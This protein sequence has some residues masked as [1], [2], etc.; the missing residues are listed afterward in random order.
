MHKGAKTIHGKA[1]S[2][3][4][5]TVI[6][7]ANAM[8]QTVPPHF[9]MPGKTRRALHGYALENI[10]KN[11]TLRDAKFSVSESGWTKDG[12]ARLWFEQTFLPNIGNYRPQLL[13]CD[14]HG[15]HNNIEFIE[16]ARSN[17][18]VVMELP[19]HTSNW[20]QPLDR[21]FFKSL[22][23]AWNKEVDN[24][25]HTTG[26]AI[27]HAQFFRLFERAW[28]VST[29]ESNIVSGFKATG[30]FPLNPSAIPAEAFVP[31]DL[32]RDSENT[33]NQSSGS[34]SETVTHPTATAAITTES[35]DTSTCP[36]LAD[37]APNVC[38]H[39][40]EEPSASSMPSVLNLDP[41]LLDASS[42]E[43]FASSFE[44]IN[45]L[46][47][48]VPIQESPTDLPLVIR[49]DGTLELTGMSDIESTTLVTGNGETLQ[50]QA[51][52]NHLLDIPK[53]VVEKVSTKRKQNAEKYFVIT[54]DK[55][56]NAK[57][58]KEEKR[59]E[60]ER[61]KTEKKIQRE[62]KKKVKAEEKVKKMNEKLARKKKV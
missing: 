18:I 60:A 32:Y 27:G 53:V 62:N 44:K 52:L 11:S 31:S 33:C 25:I 24:F 9:I 34:R 10:D 40:I 26:L 35:S 55:A 5:I 47:L 21:S 12:I 41:L 30:I 19:S 8:G 37:I 7:C 36:S 13:I 2:R 56:F 42:D 54:S 49:P 1:G 4:M 48:T 38:G 3:E 50:E 61:V 39:W 46:I 23:S 20:T 15:S 43:S 6:A 28:S 22:K 51:V 57:M 58:K 16:I 45:D 14:G 29:K 17:N 59:R